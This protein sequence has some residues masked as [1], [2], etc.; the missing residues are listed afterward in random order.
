MKRKLFSKA[1]LLFFF[2]VIS[3]ITFGQSR[4]L[5]DEEINNSTITKITFADTTRNCEVMYQWFKHDVANNTIFLFLQGGIAPVIY[6]DD[7]G[8]ESKYKVYFWDFGCTTP[9]QK[10]LIS[11]N[12]KVFDYLTNTYGKT[13]MKKIRKDV[14]GFSE[15]QKNQ[16]KRE[17]L[18][19]KSE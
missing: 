13:W 15:W 18:K 2:S 8:F 9:E 6:S 1:I 19:T 10:C 5:T 7:K 14:I 4:T 16:Q 17:S 11:Y 12:T 3:Q